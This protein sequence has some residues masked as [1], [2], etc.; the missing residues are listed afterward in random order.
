M[1]RIPL[2]ANAQAVSPEKMSR[3]NTPRRIIAL[4]CDDADV[5]EL[6]RLTDAGR[7]TGVRTRRLKLTYLP[8]IVKAVILALKKYPCSECPP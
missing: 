2:R 8:F 3:S 5:S 1:E 7:T 4:M 6:V